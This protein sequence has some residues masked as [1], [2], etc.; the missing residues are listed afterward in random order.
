MG[1]YLFIAG[2]SR[3]NRNYTLFYA[4]DA[5]QIMYVERMGKNFK[6]RSHAII[7][8]A[9]YATILKELKKISSGV[10]MLTG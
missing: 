6:Q 9:Q 2:K 5:L 8:N 3:K 4:E 1:L 7:W 10:L